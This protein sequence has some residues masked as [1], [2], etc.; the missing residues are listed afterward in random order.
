M[1]VLPGALPSHYSLQPLN[2][3]SDLQIINDEKQFTYV[4]VPVFVLQS[5]EDSSLGPT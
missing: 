1:H 4:C 2:G 3:T 5:S